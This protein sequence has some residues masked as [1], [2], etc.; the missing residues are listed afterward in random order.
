MPGAIYAYILAVDPDLLVYAIV[1]GGVGEVGP[2]LIL[3]NT[4]IY[5]PVDAGYMPVD[6][7]VKVPS[8]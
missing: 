4:S 7:L 2:T 3:D 6:G 5:M 1:G 8:L